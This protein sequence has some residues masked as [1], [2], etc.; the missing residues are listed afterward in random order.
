MCSRRARSRTRCGSCPI[1]LRLDVGRLFGGLSGSIAGVTWLTYIWAYGSA[2]LV[3]P[4]KSG[5]DR[6]M[7][8]DGVRSS[9]H[10][11]VSTSGHPG[12]LH[13]HAV[14]C[15]AISRLAPGAG[16]IVALLLS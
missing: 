2:A 13:P 9:Y 16:L 12:R 4:E 8:D 6:P 11:A 14:A 3:C 10:A 1:S 7:N 15:D 5:Q